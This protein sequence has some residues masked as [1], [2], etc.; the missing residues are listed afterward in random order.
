[1]RLN[2]IR[3]ARIPPAAFESRPQQTQ[4]S[5]TLPPGEGWGKCEDISFGQA[6]RIHSVSDRMRRSVGVSTALFIK[7]AGVQCAPL[8]MASV[9]P[10]G[11]IN[12]RPRFPAFG[13][14][15]VFRD[16]SFPY[17][18]STAIGMVMCVGRSVAE[19]SRRR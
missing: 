15:V 18:P 8:R 16:K 14:Y 2:P 12:D 1:M 9:S 7:G 4:D 19:R 6:A 17:S 13:L 10:V 11:A 5:P 3:S